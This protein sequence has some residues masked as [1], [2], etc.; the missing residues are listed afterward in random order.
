MKD[1]TSV[2]LALDCRWI[3]SIWKSVASGDAASDTSELVILG[4]VSHV[5]LKE[6][7][8][9]LHINLLWLKVEG[10]ESDLKVVFVFENLEMNELVIEQ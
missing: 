6:V 5:D 4:G 2:Q 10:F 8:N 1:S 9:I 3:G 7:S